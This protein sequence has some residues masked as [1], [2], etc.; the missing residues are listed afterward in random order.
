MNEVI[1]MHG[2]SGDSNNWKIWQ[3]FFQ[4]KNWI[5]QSG[6]RGYGPLQPQMPKWD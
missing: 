4:K 3:R 2:W 6:E 1:A 5:W